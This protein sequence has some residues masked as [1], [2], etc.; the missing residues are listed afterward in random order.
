[1]YQDFVVIYLL[2]FLCFWLSWTK[3]HHCG[4]VQQV[5]FGD[6]IACDNEKVCAYIHPIPMQR[7]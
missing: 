3:C 2:V 1:M 5:S 7:L 4:F 6:M